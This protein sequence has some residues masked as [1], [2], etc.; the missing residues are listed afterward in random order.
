MTNLHGIRVYS[1]HPEVRA[2]ARLEGCT[3]EV[4]PQPGRRPSR[5]PRLKRPG[6]HLRVTG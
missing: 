6:S 5:L 4:L 3:A 1:R 2:F